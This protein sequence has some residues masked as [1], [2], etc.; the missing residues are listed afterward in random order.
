[1]IAQRADCSSSRLSTVLKT[2]R[3]G[4]HCVS[5]AHHATNEPTLCL[6]PSLPPIARRSASRA[7]RQIFLLGQI[8][9]SLTVE[10]ECHVAHLLHRK[11]FHIYITV[12]LKDVHAGTWDNVRVRLLRRK[13]K[14]LRS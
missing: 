3:Q 2:T 12:H 5:V 7:T 4:K 1:M 13:Q 8:I 9:R 14:L 11:I 10:D 6:V